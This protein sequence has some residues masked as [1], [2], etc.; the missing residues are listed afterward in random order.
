[1]IVAVAPAVLVAGLVYHP[2]IANATDKDAVAEALVADTTRWGVAHLGVGIGSGL[3][4]LAFLAVRGRL[5]EA[6]EERWSSRG[7][8]LVVLG[9]VLFSLLPAMEIGALAGAE[10]GADVAAAQRELQPWFLPVL[11]IG[12]VAFAAGMLCFSLG[13]ARSGMLDPRL[14]RVV[15]TGLCLAAVVRVVPLGAAFYVGSVALLAGMW[16]LAYALWQDLASRSETGARPA[17]VAS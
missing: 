3:L 17:A 16:P 4:I 7:V 12:A 9:S 13:I 1:M 10:A 15:V 8:P 2:Y 14:T 11:L 6:G 5:R